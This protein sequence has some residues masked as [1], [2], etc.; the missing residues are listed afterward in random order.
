[1]LVKFKSDSVLSG[2]GFKA[3][4][5]YKPQGLGTYSFCSTLRLCQIDEGNCG[6]DLSNMEDYPFSADYECADGLKC[7]HDN[8]PPQLELSHWVDCCYQPMWKRCQDSL[9]L[10]EGV[11][12]S[13]NY[14]NYYEPYQE[15]SWLLS[16]PENSTVTLEFKSLSVSFIGFYHILVN[17]EK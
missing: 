15:C 6:H 9:D 14:P 10:K 1:M 12:S 8:C 3:A 17:R 13:P 5:D 11:L 16:V 2:R 4:I 7:G